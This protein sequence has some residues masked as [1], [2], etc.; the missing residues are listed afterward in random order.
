MYVD[1]CQDCIDLT[2]Q[3]GATGVGATVATRAYSIKVNYTL[4]GMAKAVLCS[5]PQG[6]V[7]PTY[8][9]EFTQPMNHSLADITD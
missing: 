9:G 1:V 8:C 2:F 3:L 6:C 7:K 5:L 4:L